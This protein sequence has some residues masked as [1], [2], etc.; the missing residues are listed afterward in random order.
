[1]RVNYSAIL[2]ILLRFRIHLNVDKLTGSWDLEFFTP[3]RF[4]RDQRNGPSLLRAIRLLKSNGCVDYVRI[5]WVSTVPVEPRG[6]TWKSNFGVAATM[7]WL[8]EEL[9][10]ISYSNFEF[11]DA[12]HISLPRATGNMKNG[13]QVIT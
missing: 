4:I 9:N 1:M 12:F 8:Q 5:V 3:R 7:Q 6:H 13:D 10:N 11:I 2:T